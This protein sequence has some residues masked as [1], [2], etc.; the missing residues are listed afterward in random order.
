[1]KF[2]YINFFL[3][4][5]LFGCELIKYDR[6]NKEKTKEDAV[7][8]MFEIIVWVIFGILSAL[9]IIWADLLKLWQIL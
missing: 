5:V 2:I 8:D 7:L 1:M 6:R 3:V 9:N 4:F